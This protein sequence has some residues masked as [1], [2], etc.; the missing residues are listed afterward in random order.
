MNSTWALI[1]REDDPVYFE[2]YT[3]TIKGNEYRVRRF[4][5]AV[6]FGANY[7]AS[8]GDSYDRIGNMHG[9]PTEGKAILACLEHAGIAEEAGRHFIHFGVNAYQDVKF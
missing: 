1:K 5:E 2:T 3:A 6:G 7:F 9:Y 4:G 8:V